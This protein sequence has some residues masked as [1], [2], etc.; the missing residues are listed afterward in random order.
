M[1]FN[2]VFLTILFSAYMYWAIYSA[3]PYFRTLSNS[4][5]YSAIF[6]NIRTSSANIRQY[7]IKYRRLDNIQASRPSG[8]CLRS[9]APVYTFH[10]LSA[11]LESNG[12]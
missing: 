4:G 12:Y 10:S 2:I 11:E 6:G 5:Q 7:M 8:A 9:D 3:M 1:Y